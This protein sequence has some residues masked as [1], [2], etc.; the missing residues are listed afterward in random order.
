MECVCLTWC[1]CSGKRP[2]HLREV[3]R[4]KLEYFQCATLTLTVAL[5]IMERMDRQTPM[6]VKAGDQLSYNMDRQMMP[7]E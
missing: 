3:S 6:E 1:R 4:N 2:H 7:L 5:D